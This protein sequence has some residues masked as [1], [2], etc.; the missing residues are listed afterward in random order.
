MSNGKAEI[1]F[2]KYLDQKAVIEVRNQ[3]FKGSYLI[4]LPW[5]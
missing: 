1:L 4:L 3:D 5:Q 2:R